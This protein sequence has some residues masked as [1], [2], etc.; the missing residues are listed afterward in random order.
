[1]CPVYEA[2]QL[3]QNS[4]YICRYK[5]LNTEKTSCQY[6]KYVYSAGRNRTCGRFDFFRLIPRGLAVDRDGIE[7]V[8]V[9]ARIHQRMQPQSLYGRGLYDHCN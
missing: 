8:H 7:T 5:G 4:I 6:A 3:T 9:H 2:P 1:M